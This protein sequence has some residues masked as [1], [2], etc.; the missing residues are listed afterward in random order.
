MQATTHSNRLAGETSPYLLQHAHNP[1]D[2]HPWDETALALARAENKPILLSIGYSACHW[3]HVMAHE[4]FEDADTA[5]LMNRHFVN[6]KVDREERPDLDKIYQL[7]HQLLARRPGGWPLTVFLDPHKHSPIFAGTYFPPQPRYGMPSFRH[8][9]Q[10]VAD[11]YQRNPDELDDTHRQL[12]QAMQY[13]EAT[14]AAGLPDAACLPQA[15]S[16]LAE[17][18]D[19]ENGGFGNAPKF[20]MA[21]A[22][23]FLLRYGYGRDEAAFTMAL[24]ALGSMAASGLHDHLGGGFFRYS[25][26]E[27]WEIPHF[28]KMLYDNALLLGL[29]SQAYA[30]QGDARLRAAAADTAEW[31]MAEMQAP[32][33]G[34]YATLDADSEGEEGRYYLWQRQDLQALLA[35]D[36]AAVAQQCYGLQRLANF[37]GRW[38][39][40]LV[41]EP[42]TAQAEVLLQSARA[43]L[44]AARGQR[45]RPGRDEKILSAWNGMAIRAMAMAGRWLD[46][47]RYTD[48]AARACDFLLRNAWR[49]GRLYACH[50]DGQSRFPAYLDDYAF[51]L[52]ALWELLQSRWNSDW[53]DWAIALADDLLQRFADAERGGFYFTAADHEAL[54]H[55]PKSF[56]DDSTPAG[57]GVAALAL[58]RWGYLLGEARYLQAAERTLQAAATAMSRH[59]DAHSALLTALQAHGEAPQIVILRGPADSLADWLS[60]AAL[61]WHP[62]RSAF[63]I[64][65]DAVN[66]PP[67]LAEK[68]VGPAPLAYVC[69]GHTCAAPASTPEQLRQAVMAGMAK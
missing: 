15:R 44:L 52:D 25:V 6:I 63:A 31:L 32:Q 59:P 49:D 19:Q 60:A 41:G 24:H 34:Y 36:E 38:H 64:P 30:A 55:R 48:S 11:Y 51:L 54:L 40:R 18:Y 68:T 5:A 7:A 9:L 47:P 35:P 56:G 66:L 4:S 3:C 2:W 65:N 20:P 26:D 12:L 22:L 1:V 58:L 46:Q 17:L 8:V 62:R 61:P 37:E 57:N 21:A 42:D 23:E 43:K 29:Y 67:A 33:G 10:Q 39:L 45:V 13:L 16:A 50:K 28:E 53:L 14:E 27:R 69:I